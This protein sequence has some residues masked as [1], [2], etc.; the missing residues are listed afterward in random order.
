VWLEYGTW[1]GDGTPMT[2][3]IDDDGDGTIDQTVMV[4]DDGN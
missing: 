3:S 4:S 1:A 2:V